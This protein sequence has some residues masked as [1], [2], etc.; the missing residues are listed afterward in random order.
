MIDVLITTYNRL[1]FLKRTLESLLESNLG[2][3]YRIHVI[4]DSSTDGTKE[5]LSELAKGPL[6]SVIL[7]DERKGVV[8][9]FNQLWDI[10]ILDDR[11]P[12]LCYLQDDMIATKKDWLMVLASAWH[13]MKDAYSIGFFSGYDAPEHPVEKCVVWAEDSVRIKRS[14]SAQNL[15]ADKKFW[16]SI[17]KPPELNL[18]GSVRGFPDNGR[19]S[20]I[21]VW[22]T[23]CYSMSRYDP[24][25]AAPNCLYNQEKKIMVVPMLKHLGVEKRDST[26]RQNRVEGF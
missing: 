3:H 12:F 25:A 26:W 16:A 4:D 8:H 13:E 11:Y 21:D 15:F 9:N 17:G 10:L 24:N 1:Q 2:F 23:G 7:S 5:Y 22:F 14:T 20:N 18:N 19:G 6:D